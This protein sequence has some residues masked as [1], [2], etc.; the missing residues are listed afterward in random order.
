LTVIVR[1][2]SL[3]INIIKKLKSFQNA[4]ESLKV[5][6]INALIEIMWR[7][8]EDVKVIVSIT[9][10]TYYSE[11]TILEMLVDNINKHSNR[12]FVKL[13]LIQRNP[14]YGG[15]SVVE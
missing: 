2:L 11:N 5:L 14:T 12:L 13:E 6:P 3:D 8:L 9:I 15:S 1:K 4:L 10:H 7:K